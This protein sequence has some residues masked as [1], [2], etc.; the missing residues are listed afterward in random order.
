MGCSVSDSF[1]GV[2]VILLFRKAP[3]KI[4]FLNP[5]SNHVP[6]QSGGHRPKGRRVEDRDGLAWWEKTG[7]RAERKMPLFFAKQIR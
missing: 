1:C 2:G 5:P 6:A 4:D 7:K 3:G